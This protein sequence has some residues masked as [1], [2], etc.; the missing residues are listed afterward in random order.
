MKHGGFALGIR[1]IKHFL[2]GGKLLVPGILRLALSRC[3][4]LLIGL[5]WMY[6][7]GRH[8]VIRLK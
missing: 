4:R 3:Q 6:I 2:K 7:L 1:V 8:T 5:I